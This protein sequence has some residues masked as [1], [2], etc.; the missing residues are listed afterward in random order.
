MEQNNAALYTLLLD[1]IPRSG[2]AT[3][4]KWK[5]P[6]IPWD[7]VAYLVSITVHSSQ[8]LKK[9][10]LIKKL[11]KINNGYQVANCIQKLYPSTCI[12]LLT[13]MATVGTGKS[14]E[15]IHIFQGSLL[16]VQ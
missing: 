6:F 3:N 12:V 11:I 7:M 15:Q 16:P 1:L 10:W 4:D 2:F 9:E 8:N 14:M 13:A 5:F